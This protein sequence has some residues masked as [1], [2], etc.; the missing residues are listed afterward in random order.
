MG[1]R[2]RA[3]TKFTKPISRPTMHYAD[4]PTGPTSPCAHE[5]IWGYRHSR[6]TGEDIV[7]VARAFGITEAALLQTALRTVR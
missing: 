4:N 6:L 3:R 7:A 1:T 5:R 2:A